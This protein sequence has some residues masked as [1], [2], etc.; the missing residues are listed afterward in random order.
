[1]YNIQSSTYY[2][3]VYKIVFAK[4]KMFSRRVGE[5]GEKCAADRL[6]N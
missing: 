1:M 6:G 2:M 3:I 5:T 4:K